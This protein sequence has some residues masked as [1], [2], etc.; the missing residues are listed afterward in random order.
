MRIPRVKGPDRTDK[1]ADHFCVGDIDNMIVIGRQGLCGIRLASHCSHA[2]AVTGFPQEAP[3]VHPC[4]CGSIS[5][6]PGRFRYERVEPLMPRIRIRPD[7]RSGDVVPT[8]NSGGRH[9]GEVSQP[10]DWYRPCVLGLGPGW[11]AP[12]SKEVISAK[13]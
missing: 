2:P 3:K 1:P 9:S 11:V 5:I 4:Q 13:T 10:V 7:D 12:V 6:P 8:S